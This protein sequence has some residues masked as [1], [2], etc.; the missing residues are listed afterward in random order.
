MRSLPPD[1]VIRESGQYSISMDAYH[2]QPCDGPSISSTGLAVIRRA[3]TP[4][5]CWATRSV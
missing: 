2:G 3:W 5:Y 1:G 4:S